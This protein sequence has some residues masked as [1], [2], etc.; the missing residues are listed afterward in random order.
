[1]A[2]S[3]TPHGEDPRSDARR[4]D[5]ARRRPLHRRA[6]SAFIARPRPLHV[7]LLVICF[8]LGAA[9]VTQVRA[10]QTDPLDKMSQEDLV[11][12]LDQLQTRTD[13]LRGEKSD[14]EEQLS[15]LQDAASKNEAA[16][17]A[18]Q[19]SLEQAEISA[20]TIPVH[21]P[22]LTMTVTDPD[23]NL[24]FT[25][26][27][28]AL[29]ELRNADAEAI[30]LNGVRLTGQSS[31]TQGSTDSTI[32]VDGTQISS[33]YVWQIIGSS[34]DISQALEIPSG[35]AQQMRTGTGATVTITAVD[36]VTITAVVEAQTPE[37]AK[38]Q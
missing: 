18:A 32:S 15:T 21:G 8:F 38:V 24:N 4:P 17:A 1:M 14:L 29:G 20:G 10:Q 19:K 36:D 37:F 13:T 16:D 9:L 12:L 33:P 23:G 25:N 22:G 31:F 27:V 30:S 34:A 3:E 5:D 7:V 11:L 28:L 26:F 2:M 35:A 6:W